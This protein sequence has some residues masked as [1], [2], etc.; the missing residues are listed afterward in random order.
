MTG[1]GTFGPSFK[2]GGNILPS[3]FV[4]ISTT[5]DDTVLACVAGDDPFGISQEGVDQPPGVAGSDGNAGRAGENMKV[6]G[7]G[8]QCLITLGTGGCARG[9]YLKPAAAGN[10]V[11]ASTAAD[12]YGAQALEIGAAGE[13]ILVVVIKGKI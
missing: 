11:T 12:K 8:S 6:Y 9:D 7:P 4:K 2:A 1:L 13:K 3:I 10:G 5:A